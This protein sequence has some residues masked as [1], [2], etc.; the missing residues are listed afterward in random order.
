MKKM[1]AAVW[2]ALLLLPGICLTAV[3]AAESGLVGAALAFIATLVVTVSFLLNLHGVSRNRA[4]SRV[5]MFAVG[6]IFTIINC[7]V[8]MYA[9]IV[10]VGKVSFFSDGWAQL[11]FILAL[12]L[13]VIVAFI[14]ALKVGLP[15]TMDKRRR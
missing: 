2:G 14:I 12:I 15:S 6:F 5:M 9:L 8:F 13:P 1:D 11:L 3:A 10:G 7:F 4:N